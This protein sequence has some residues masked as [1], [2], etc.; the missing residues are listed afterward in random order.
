MYSIDSVG[1]NWLFS[2][3]G[4]SSEIL[5]CAAAECGYFVTSVTSALKMQ[6]LCKLRVPVQYIF[7]KEK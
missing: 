6:E 2:K 1:D 7:M 5:H 4:L 3:L